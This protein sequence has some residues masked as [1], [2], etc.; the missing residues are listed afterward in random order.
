MKSEN[1]GCLFGKSSKIP[2]ALMTYS[3]RFL[4]KQVS[5]RY[6]NKNIKEDKHRIIRKVETQ[7][8]YSG[9]SLLNS[10]KISKQRWCDDRSATAENLFK[11][12]NV[13]I[14]GKLHS[15][16]YLLNKG[17]V[18]RNLLLNS[19]FYR[20]KAKEKNI[21][22]A[23]MHL[24]YKDDLA[25]HEIN[26]TMSDARSALG[27]L[28][29]TCKNE[30]IPIKDLSKALRSLKRSRRNETYA[31]HYYHFGNITK[32]LNYYQNDIAKASAKFAKLVAQPGGIQASTNS[33]E[34]YNAEVSM[35][36]MSMNSAKM[37]CGQLSSAVS[38]L[39]S[40]SSK[41]TQSFMSILGGAIQDSYRKSVNSRSR[42]SSSSS[43]EPEA[44]TVE[45]LNSMWSGFR[46][47][48]KKSMEAIRLSRLNQAKKK[49]E[50]LNSL[51]QVRN[52]YQRTGRVPT[53]TPQ[54]NPSAACIAK[55]GKYNKRSNNC[56]IYKQTNTAVLTKLPVN[57]VG[58]NNNQQSQTSNSIN[59]SST[60][61]SSN[62]GESS[63]CSNPNYTAPSFTVEGKNAVPYNSVGGKVNTYMRKTCGSDRPSYNANPTIKCEVIEKIKSKVFSNLTRERCTS[64]PFTFTC[65]CKQKASSGRAM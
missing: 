45:S 28:S 43:S 23:A 57:R 3:N 25:L 20:Y 56:T 2:M 22:E 65:S 5:R 55:G 19:P 54:P 44:G 46:E 53:S 62:T 47:A 59:D 17:F 10:L 30:I 48:N 9:S 4:K 29:Y 26:Q 27:H 40:G 13:R 52:N 31:R 6:Y 35:V 41:K 64:E 58:F 37:F 15:N 39:G 24:A 11:N 42:Y 36:P 32:R 49:R 21:S 51:Q 7:T 63:A 14:G 38:A 18:I 16:F 50:Y 33:L 60:S 1:I 34:N 12:I 8:F 61:S